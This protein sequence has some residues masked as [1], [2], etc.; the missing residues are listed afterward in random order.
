MI[1]GGNGDKHSNNNERLGLSLKKLQ[2]GKN[3]RSRE[4]PAEK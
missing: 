3:S 2:V 4:K 1:K